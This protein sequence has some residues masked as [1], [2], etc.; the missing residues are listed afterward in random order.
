VAEPVLGKGL[1]DE[2]VVGLETADRDSQSDCLLDEVDDLGI[3]LVEDGEY[4]F[5]AG[6]G[7]LEL[8]LHEVADLLDGLGRGLVEQ[9]LGVPLLVHEEQDLDFLV[10]AHALDV[11]VGSLGV[12]C[13][14]FAFGLLDY[15][16]LMGVVDGD[17]CGEL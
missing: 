3:V 15:G 17:G 6:P 5:A 7:L 2:Q 9:D 16:L 1:E 4:E 13:Q 12:S 10:P 8:A 11:G 14:Q